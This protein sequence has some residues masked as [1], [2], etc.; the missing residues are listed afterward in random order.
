MAEVR[1]NQENFRNASNKVKK[2][3]DL[4]KGKGKRKENLVEQNIS[5]SD[6]DDE[7]N[8][9]T[10]NRGNIESRDTNEDLSQSNTDEE[11]DQPEINKKEN[12][13]GVT[14]PDILPVGEKRRQ[15]V[16]WNQV[17][18]PIGKASVRFS[19][20]LGR[21]EEDSQFEDDEESLTITEDAQGRVQGPEQPGCVRGW[22]FGVT[23]KTLEAQRLITTWRK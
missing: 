17:G 2:K 13:R 11:I 22:G 18:Q 4:G 5:N 7:N 19:T 23:L 1:E 16:E 9:P 8:D 14:R 6:A 20:A 12:V 21:V 10:T 3:A 15:T